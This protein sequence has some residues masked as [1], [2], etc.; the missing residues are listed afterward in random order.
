[1]ENK[2]TFELSEEMKNIIRADSVKVFDIKDI[3]GDGIIINADSVIAKIEKA[4]TD[5]LYNGGKK[6][7]ILQDGNGKHYHR[8]LFWF[9]VLRRSCRNL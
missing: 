4:M 1:M 5:I 9:Y 8:R 3:N 7:T 2:K 6:T